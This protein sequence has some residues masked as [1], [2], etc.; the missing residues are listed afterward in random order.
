MRGL[1]RKFY[2]HCL[3]GFAK[4]WARSAYLA[5]TASRYAKRYPGDRC[6]CNFCGFKADQFLA[7]G[8]DHPVLIEKQVVGGGPRNNARCPRCY[9]LDRERQ[10]LAVLMQME[11][12][13]TCRVLH[14][15][16]EKNL[17]ASLRR[18]ITDSVSECDLL[19]DKYS[20]AKNISRQDLT[21][22]TYED[23]TFDLVVAN[24][25][26]EHIPDDV[27]AFREIHRVLRPGGHAIL[28]VPYSDALAEI[29]E[30]LTNFDPDHQLSRFGQVSHV[31]I[32]TRTEFLRRARA[33]GLQSRFKT[34]Q[35]VPGYERL[36]F[37]PREGIFLFQATGDEPG[38]LPVEPGVAEVL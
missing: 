10:I 31:R 38:D 21:Q 9:S 13:S 7:G 33:A 6:Q 20:W 32:Y 34:A 16:P 25:V 22:L 26:L 17:N 12:P 4:R 11:L 15:A 28:Q 1:L 3:P 14:V 18:L 2:I 23:Q 8:Y 24:H 5:S 30:D 29:D 37:D 36:A 19:P 27:A 35:E